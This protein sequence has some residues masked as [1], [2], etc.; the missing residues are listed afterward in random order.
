MAR[1]L[2]TFSVNVEEYAPLITSN[3]FISTLINWSPTI[4]NRGS[5]NHGGSCLFAEA[6]SCQLE[7]KYLAKLTNAK[8]YYQGVRIQLRLDIRT[9]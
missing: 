8:E 7:F 1:T 9:N 4:L 5:I 6:A 2:P 3:L